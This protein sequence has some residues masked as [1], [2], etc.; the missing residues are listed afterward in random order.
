MLIQRWMVLGCRIRLLHVGEKRTVNK[1]FGSDDVNGSM[2][3]VYTLITPEHMF[4]ISAHVVV[5]GK[6]G[7]SFKMIKQ[8]R[9]YSVEVKTTECGTG[10]I[11]RHG[12]L[13]IKIPQS[14][15]VRKGE[16]I[17]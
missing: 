9:L 12:S 10:R 17:S 11:E 1:T 7:G 14:T 5:M 15:K 2:I 13:G 4:S 8:P 6:Y 16:Q 3:A